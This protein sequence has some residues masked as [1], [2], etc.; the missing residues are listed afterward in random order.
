[1]TDKYTENKKALFME[2]QRLTNRRKLQK[3]KD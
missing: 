3:E 1:M 2:Y